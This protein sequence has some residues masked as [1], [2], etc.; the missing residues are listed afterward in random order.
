MLDYITANLPLFANLDRK[1]VVKI[2]DIGEVNF[3]QANFLI[4]GEALNSLKKLPDSLV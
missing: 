3:Q 4:N 1:L 2:D